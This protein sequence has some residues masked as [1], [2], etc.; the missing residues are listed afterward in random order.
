MP[1]T[2]R[3]WLAWVVSVSDRYGRP[4]SPRYEYDG[5]PDHRMSDRRETSISIRIIAERASHAVCGNGVGYKLLIDYYV[6]EMPWFAFSDPDRA[7]LRRVIRR[8]AAELRR[9]GFLPDP[10]DG[11]GGGRGL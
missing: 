5:I 11:E 4:H 7:L 6:G 3:G 9:A 8:Y 10:K 1:S 2:P